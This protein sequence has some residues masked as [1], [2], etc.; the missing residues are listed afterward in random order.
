MDNKTIRYTNVRY[1]VDL[2]GGVS[3][4]AQRLD[5]GQSQTSQFA[6][7]NP[8]KGIGNKIAREIE[9]AFSKPH[10]WLDVAHPELW[11]VQSNI[12]QDTSS[13]SPS[14]SHLVQKLDLLEQS[15]S[16]TK[17]EI[18]LIN[19]TVDVLSK[20][21]KVN[22]TIDLQ[23]AERANRAIFDEEATTNDRTE[24]QK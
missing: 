3:N 18:D 17:E 19:Q 8:I 14:L 20:S 2:I 13:R 7:T 9:D 23:E 22:R 1:L 6:G 21:K 11:G 15:Q 16:L 10:G 12:E 4:F 5:K 24:D